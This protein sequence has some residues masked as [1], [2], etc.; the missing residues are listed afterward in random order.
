PAAAPAAV[1]P[2]GPAGANRNPPA[3][4]RT[5]RLIARTAEPESSRPAAPLALVTSVAVLLLAAITLNSVRHSPPVSPGPQLAVTT[6][7]PQEQPEVSPPLASDSAARVPTSQPVPLDRLVWNAGNAWVGLT[8]ATMT[9]VTT[10]ALATTGTGPRSESVDTENPDAHWLRELEGTLGPVRDD[11][12]RT[13]EF[14]M[15]TLPLSDASTI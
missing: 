5:A 14:L 8:A 7:A 4:G 6:P 9:Q 10:S 3:A 11:L 2:A 13:V 1:L 12:S 15:E